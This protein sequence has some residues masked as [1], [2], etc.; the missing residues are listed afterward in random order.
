MVV[1]LTSHRLVLILHI[2]LL[3]GH[4]SLKVLL[5]IITSIFASRHHLV[6]LHNKLYTYQTHHDSLNHPICVGLSPQTTVISYI[7][8]RTPMT[9][10]I[11][12]LTFSYSRWAASTSSSDFC[13]LHISSHPSPSYRFA[14]AI[15][16]CWASAFFFLVG[17]KCEERSLMRLSSLSVN[18]SFFSLSFFG[19]NFDRFGSLVFFCWSYG[20]G[21]LFGV[22]RSFGIVF[23]K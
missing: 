7:R 8:V 5:G 2:Y 17:F 18:S 22:L 4:S 13:S 23:R 10:S 11:S 21:E 19:F 9:S 3:H 20:F 14:L 1:R 15:L 16:P 6:Q 12:R